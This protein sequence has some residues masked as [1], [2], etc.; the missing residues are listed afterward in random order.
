MLKQSGN[1]Q[2]S[3]LLSVVL[4]KTTAVLG[5]LTLATFYFLREPRSFHP[6]LIK[7]KTK[8]FPDH[9]FNLIIPVTRPVVFGRTPRDAMWKLTR[10]LSGR[11]SSTR[12][13]GNRR[14]W[15]PRHQWSSLVIIPFI[16]HA[17][18]EHV[19]QESNKLIKKFYCQFYL[20]SLMVFGFLD[21]KFWILDLKWRLSV[22]DLITCH[23]LQTF[24]NCLD[25]ANGLCE[26][27]LMQCWLCC[28]N[29]VPE[30]FGGAIIIGQESITYH[31]GDKYLAIAPPTIKVKT[32]NTV[33]QLCCTVSLKRR[34]LWSS[35]YSS[36][37]CGAY[38]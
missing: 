29:L 25:H 34:L 22:N 2:K 28:C 27:V 17:I 26:V 11:R 3:C 5:S 13:P 9:L 16:L 15:R 4:A 6:N 12:A 33:N 23:Q 20:T 14:T 38:T 35:D 8:T 19:K 32:W 31:N 36:V 7:K 37:K 30:P 1:E 18:K 10:F 24:L 21:L